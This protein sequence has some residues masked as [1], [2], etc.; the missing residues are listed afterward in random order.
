MNCLIDQNKKHCVTKFLFL[1]HIKLLTVHKIKVVVGGLVSFGAKKRQMI[2]TLD[3]MD[4]GG[5]SL[6][7]EDDENTKNFDSL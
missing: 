1:T 7:Y 5:E 2:L 4:R 3:I 6:I